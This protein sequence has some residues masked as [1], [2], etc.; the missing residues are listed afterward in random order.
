MQAWSLIRQTFP[1]GACTLTLIT[2]NL[3][4]PPRPGSIDEKLFAS[5][6]A[7]QTIDEMALKLHATDY[8]LYNRLYAYFHMGALKIHEPT[9]PQHDIDRRPG[10]G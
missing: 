9:G 2:E 4:E 6:A 3:E 10:S 8:F 5:I 1:S 7:G